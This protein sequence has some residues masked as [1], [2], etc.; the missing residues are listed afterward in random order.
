MKRLLA[1][2][3]ALCFVLSFAGCEP[4]GDDPEAGSSVV[5]PD[6]VGMDGDMEATDAEAAIDS[7]SSGAVRGPGAID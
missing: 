6:G 4:Y 5:A 2:A 3:A 7:G 1:S